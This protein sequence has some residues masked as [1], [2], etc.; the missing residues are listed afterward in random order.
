VNKSFDPYRKWLGISAKDQ[1]PNHYR[2]LGIDPLETDPDVI[3][4]AADG[5]MVQLKNVQTGKYSE[6]FQKLLNE[7]AAATVCLLGPEKKAKY[8]RAL[9]AKL[10]GQRGRSPRRLPRRRRYRLQWPIPL[11]GQRP[12][13]PL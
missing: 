3:S 4:N 7:I 8:D 9:R 13:F 11:A 1:P 6:Y 5:R 10:E 12:M 2:L